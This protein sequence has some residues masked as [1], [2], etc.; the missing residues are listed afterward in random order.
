MSPYALSLL[1]FGTLAGAFV[2]SLTMDTRSPILYDRLLVAGFG[3]LAGLVSAFAILGGWYFA[4]AGF[5][6]VGD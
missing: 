1:L 6:L 4:A 5:A 3:A 2:S